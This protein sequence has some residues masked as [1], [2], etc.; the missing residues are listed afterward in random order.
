LVSAT[1]EACP[2]GE[3]LVDS[4]NVLKNLSVLPFGSHIISK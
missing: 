2:S 4:N 1:N 3:F